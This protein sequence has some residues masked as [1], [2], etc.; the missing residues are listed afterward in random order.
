MSIFEFWEEI[1]VIYIIILN[2]KDIFCYFGYKEIFSFLKTLR[3]VLEILKPI[4]N[5]IFETIKSTLR[6][7]DNDYYTQYAEEYKIEYDVRPS[8]KYVDFYTQNYIYP[9]FYSKFD[10]PFNADPYLKLKIK[11]KLGSKLGSK[12][13]ECNLHY[14]RNYLSCYV[15]KGENCEG[16]LMRICSCTKHFI[17]FE[18]LN[19]DIDKIRIGDNLDKYIYPLFQNS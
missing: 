3:P 17:N 15:I 12:I 1:K 6:I 8:K 16:H 2:V 14:V 18:I 5:L 10:G 13:R 7:L 9:R 11:N 4:L 19:L